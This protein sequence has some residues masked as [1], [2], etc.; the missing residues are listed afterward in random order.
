MT[1]AWTEEMIAALRDLRAQ[2]AAIYFCAEKIGVSYDLAVHKCRELGIA[3]RRNRGRRRASDV[4]RDELRRK[5][6]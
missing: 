2:G 4:I 6:S 3:N 5:T 1:V